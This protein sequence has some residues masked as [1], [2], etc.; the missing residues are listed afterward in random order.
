MKILMLF[1]SSLFVGV[2]V[3][4]NIKETG[5][6]LLER[7]LNSGLNRYTVKITRQLSRPK[8]RGRGYC[9]AGTEIFLKVF[10]PGLRKPV[11]SRLVDSCL[12][13]L[14][15]NGKDF[16][17]GSAEFIKEPIKIKDS[18]IEI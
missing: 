6:L 16:V 7:K 15:L 11:F 1:I 2:S 14:D 3:L 13:S 12:E 9:G 17:M 5:E 8:A 18:S 10:K 4:A